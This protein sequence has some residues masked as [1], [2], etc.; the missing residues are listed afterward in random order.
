MKTVTLNQ[1]LEEETWNADVVT[2]DGVFHADEVFAVALLKILC[3]LS[4][5]TKIVRTRDKDF[6]EKAKSDSEIFV[7]DVGQ[8]LWRERKNFDHHQDVNIR[9]AFGLVVA[10]YLQELVR[11]VEVPLHGIFTRKFMQ[12]VDTIDDWDCNRNNA[13]AIAADLP[14]GWRNLSQ[15]IAGFNRIEYGDDY[16]NDAFTEAVEFAIAILHNEIY[17][18]QKAAEA[19]LAYD[20]RLIF[21]NN[22]ALFD[23]FSPVWKSKGDHLFAVMPH[24]NG[25]QVLARDTALAIIP[26]NAGSFPGFIFRHAAGFIA[27]FTTKEN[28]VNFAKT[29]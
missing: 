18:T 13:H 7:I 17:A 27:T 5:Q 29:L 11:G 2:H 28:A 6:L 10:A 16:Q 22:I 4:G 3:K 15:I 25:W 24:T 20:S 12:F 21:G 23:T 9:S 14:A 19:D 1:H 26:S 8:S